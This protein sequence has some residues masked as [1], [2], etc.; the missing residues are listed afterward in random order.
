MKPFVLRVGRVW[1]F[2]GHTK[3]SLEEDSE[4]LTEL[5]SK[6]ESVNTQR[7]SVRPVCAL[8]SWILGGE[9]GK[10]FSGQ[11]STPSLFLPSW[12]IMTGSN[13]KGCDRW[14]NSIVFEITWKLT[15]EAL[16]GCLHQE[17]FKSGKLPQSP[18][19]SLH[20]I[21]GSASETQNSQLW[22]S[23]LPPCSEATLKV[24]C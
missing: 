16:Q 23:T 7:V 14:K 2:A 6:T 21:P 5:Q 12:H 4:Y 20:Q 8:A 9:A 1:E 15:A 11:E 3:P 19:E 18:W 22:V 24:A 10:Q 13:P 17:W